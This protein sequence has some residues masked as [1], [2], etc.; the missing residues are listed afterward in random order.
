MIELVELLL[1]LNKIVD[2]LQGLVR[3]RFATDITS[4]LL[5]EILKAENKCEYIVSFSCIIILCPQ[6][7]SSRGN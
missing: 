3:S 1:S 7:E 5:E 2:L 6:I 4:V